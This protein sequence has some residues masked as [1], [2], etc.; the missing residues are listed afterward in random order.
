MKLL[1]LCDLV[2]DKSGAFEEFLI[3]LGASL[4]DSGDELFVVLAGKPMEQIDAALREARIKWDIVEEWK[5]HSSFVAECKEVLERDHPDLVSVHFGNELPLRRL[6]KETK[7]SALSRVKWVWHQRQQIRPPNIIS[8]RINRISM[9]N[10]FCDHFVALYQGGKKSLQLRGV[11]DKKVSVIQN[12]V[13]EYVLEKEEGWLRN[14]LGLTEESIIVVNT[15]SLI[16]RKRV[17]ECI[18]AFSLDSPLEPDSRHLLIIGTG[19]EELNLRQLAKDSGI[20][21]KVHFLGRRN[22]VREIFAESDLLVLTSSAE[23]SPLSIAEAMSVGLPCLVTDAGAARELIVDNETGFV[24]GTDDFNAF[25]ERLSQL[26]ADQAL[27]KQMGL[28][29]TDRW[30]KH[31]RLDRMVQEHIDLYRRLLG[32]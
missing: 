27:R 31:F 20:S 19:P 11:S 26:I 22:D 15:S 16:L 21:G 10:R 2:P 32:E 29:A 4:K 9:L 3:S 23:A 17:A 12:G 14:E 28:A 18:K 13:S 25:T 30:D 7:K 24:V 8:T 5:R 6:I 1:L